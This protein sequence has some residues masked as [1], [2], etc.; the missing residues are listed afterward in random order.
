MLIARDDLMSSHLTGYLRNGASPK[1]SGNRH[2]SR[3][4]QLLRR[5]EWDGHARRQQSC[6]SSAGCGSCWSVRHDQAQTTRRATGSRREAGVLT[7]ILLSA[8]RTNGNIL[9]GAPRPGGAGAPNCGSRADPSSRRA[10]SPTA[11]RSPPESRVA[12][13]Y[14]LRRLNLSTAAPASKPAAGIGADT[15]AVLAEHGYAPSEIADFRR[16]GVI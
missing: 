12:S 14:R 10:A 2:A 8:A 6:G 15:N 4:Q 5:Q 9:S 16:A 1:P 7:D 13:G 3:H 11:T